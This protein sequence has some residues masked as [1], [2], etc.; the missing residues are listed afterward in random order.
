MCIDF[1]ARE[2]ERAVKR[3][4]AVSD[5]FLI[6]GMEIRSGW[7]GGEGWQEKARTQQFQLIIHMQSER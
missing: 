1:R 7:E 3:I 5:D 4:W 2:R 6:L